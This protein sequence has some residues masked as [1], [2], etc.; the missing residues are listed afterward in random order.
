[1]FIKCLQVGPLPTNCYIACDTVSN[2]A[3]IIDPGAEAGRILT[4]FEETGCELLYIL[5]THAH[6]DH[7]TAAKEIIEKT[8]AKLVV[9]EGDKELLND[10]K[11][12]CWEMVKEVPFEPLKPD[13]LLH[14]GETIKFG[15]I[16]LRCMETPGHTAG[17][18]CYLGADSMFSGDT[19]FK[20]SVGRT[21]LSTGDFSKMKFSVSRIKSLDG[22]MQILP[23]HGEFTSLSNERENNPYFQ[24]Q[25]K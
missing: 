23:G 12:N 10:P 21:D 15:S 17:S 2:T 20:G 18:V 4:A 13:I 8:G 25:N 6:A 9:P 22:N 11:N 24:E 19:V 16:E 14:D 3:V 7:F 5:L 1:M